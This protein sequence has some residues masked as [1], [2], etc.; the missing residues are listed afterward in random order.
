M[1]ADR[2]YSLGLAWGST[3]EA[4]TIYPEMTSFAA[5]EQQVGGEYA[6]EFWGDWEDGVMT[7]PKI[8]A[9]DEPLGVKRIAE[10]TGF[11]R[12]YIK[13]EIKAGRLISR[14][15]PAV[16]G[17]PYHEI[18]PDDFIAWVNNPQ[19]GERGGRSKKKSE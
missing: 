13:A 9:G 15:V 1:D 2:A 19:K 6:G 3:F 12:S 17:K 10:I 8:I 4:F 18:Q 14:L 16:I 7:A 11:D 5:F